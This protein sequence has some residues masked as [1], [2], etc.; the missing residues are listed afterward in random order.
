VIPALALI[1]Y[2]ANGDHNARVAQIQ[3]DAERIVE[4]AASRQARFIDSAQHLLPLLSEIS[5]VK[6]GDAAACGR[7]MKGVLARD[8]LYANL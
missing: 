5:A 3:E 6:K 1:L 7:F 4:M 8:R 2:D